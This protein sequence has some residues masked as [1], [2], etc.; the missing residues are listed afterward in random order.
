[1]GVGS[2]DGKTVGTGEGTVV[3]SPLGSGDGKT[4]GTGEGTVVGSPLGSGDGKAVGTGEG[5]VVGSPLGSGDGRGDGRVVG[6]GVGTAVGSGLGLGV[7][8]MDVG[9]AVGSGLGLGVVGTDVGTAVGSG[10]GLGV[11]GTDVG[12]GVVCSA[13]SAS[14]R[15][16]FQSESEFVLY[17]S[18]DNHTTKPLPYGMLAT[19]TYPEYVYTELPSVGMELDVSPVQALCAVKVDGP[20]ANTVPSAADVSRLIVPLEIADVAANDQPK[21]LLRSVVARELPSAD[22]T[23]MPP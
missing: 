14:S 5:T 10:L 4:V 9:T 16:S 17:Q 23:M 19:C 13:L 18:N 22:T 6:R 15:T 21:T 20:V 2:G 12:G 1:M 8:G 3:G 11:V 7:V